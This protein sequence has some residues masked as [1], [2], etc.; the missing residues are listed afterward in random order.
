MKKPAERM[1]Y[2]ERQ[3]DGSTP[4]WRMQT[5]WSAAAGKPTMTVTIE[6]LNILDEVVWFDARRD[7]HP[8]VRRIA[9]HARDICDAD[10]DYPIIMTRSG[11]VL[12][13]AHRIAKAYLHGKQVISAVVLDDWPSPD[14]AVVDASSNNLE[15][16][17]RS[18]PNS[19]DKS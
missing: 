9:Q 13:G 18:R 10:L 8:T 4:F 15:P 5:I 12:D 2:G 17:D 14:G 7:V 11:D 19:V 1:L 6:D 3:P 16:P